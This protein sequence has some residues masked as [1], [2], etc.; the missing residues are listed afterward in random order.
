MKALEEGDYG[1]LTLSDTDASPVSATPAARLLA[2][3]QALLGY[4]DA[5]AACDITRRLTV[6]YEAMP[7]VGS[8]LLCDSPLVLLWILLPLLP[9]LPPTGRRPQ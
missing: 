3:S 1:A 6:L 7:A 4:L 2:L 8:H 5:P 9:P